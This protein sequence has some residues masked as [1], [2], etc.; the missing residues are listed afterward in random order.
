[1]TPSVPVC[2]MPS[3][4][5]ALGRIELEVPQG[6]TVAEIIAV[7]LPGATADALSRARVW[8][9]SNAGETLL[10][11][12]AAWHRIRPRPGVRV[13]IKL[14]AGD[15]DLKT[16]L[17]IAVSIAATAI[18]QVWVGPALAAATGSALIGQI[19]AAAVAAGIT[20]AGG[21]LINMLIP[22]A[23]RADQQS[24]PPLFSISGWQNQSA[25]D[26]VVPS[27][28]GKVRV[29]P[30]FAAP[31]YSE[32]V[33][34]D[35]YIRCLFTFGY[36]PV[37]LSGLKIKDTPLSSFNEVD[38]EIRDGYSSDDPVSIYPSQ[39][40][41]DSLGVE[42]RRDRTRNSSGDIT[43]TGPVT[44]VSRFTAGD[45]T[46]AN[47]IFSFPGGLTDFHEEGD[48]AGDP[49]TARVQ[50]RIRQ[51]PASGGSWQTVKT[52][53]FSGKTRV[54]FF[55]QYRWSLPS[56]GRWEIE[57]ARITHEAVETE[58]SD[59]STWLS[60]QSFRPEYPINF[61]KPL[62]LV[63]MRIKATYQLNSTLDTFNAIAERLIPDWDHETEQWVVRPTRNPASHFRHA[64]QGPERAFP[65]P[66]SAIDL[67]MLQDWHDFCRVKGLKYDRNRNF[68]ASIWDT[69]TEIAAAGRAAPRYD[70]TKWQVIIDR[71]QELV[72]AHINDRNSRDFKWSR[73]YP[74]FPDAFRVQFLDETNDYQERERIV[75]WPGY[76]GD[77]NVTEQLTMPGKTDP[78]EIWVE[79]RRRQYEAIY[80]PDVFT[81]VQD[82]AVR[83]ATRG[84]YVKGSY[85]TLSYTLATFRVSVVRDQYVT[86]DGWVEMEAGTNYAVR[87]MRQVGE[88][89]AATFESVLRQVVTVPGDS[90]S[91]ALAGDGYAPLAGDIVQFGI[92]GQESIDL[93]VAGTQAGE[94]MTSVLTMLA[95][96]P[97]IDQLTDAEVPP[98]WN[99][100]AGG[101]TAAPIDIPAVPVV[102]SIEPY[103]D[104]STGDPDGVIVLLHP[105]EG[106][107]A[108]VTSFTLRHRLEGTATW[109]DV[110]VD[111]ADGA[112][113]ATG[114]AS[115][116]E[117]EMQVLATSLYGYSSDWSDIFTASGA[118]ADP[119]P[120]PQPITS[121]SV[122]GGTGEAS[123]DITTANDIWIDTV[124]LYYGPNGD[125]SGVTLIVN[126]AADPLSNYERTETVP[127][128]TWYFF[129]VTFNSEGTPSVGFS[130]GQET[131]A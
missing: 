121:G 119:E 11:A 47:I 88:S 113:L 6:L 59:R 105:G 79:A 129:A 18:G 5:P 82:G 81:A 67:A 86:F 35:Q 60:L 32:I 53:T 33:G 98:E 116:A 25:P 15:I 54:G 120:T 102:S 122:T 71:P 94:N 117:I 76:T 26:G 104:P 61:D 36:G 125:G 12:R 101:D 93:V 91:V 123:F 89:D 100:R 40:I 34:D 108:Y 78:E 20:L 51:R 103:F 41:E 3:L 56:R 1:M 65:E 44:P 55:R 48:D 28:L 17:T 74:Q 24:E 69:L 21:Y 95:Q 130:L 87:F 43:G 77:I 2:A 75:R 19:G 70:G 118:A 38:Y 109:T 106:S 128:G 97:I 39:V 114:Y 52:I 112:A 63:A 7:V 92:A 90:D 8:L 30:V 107:S 45:A 37:D 58:I 14:V 66:D 115:G 124:G 9:V 84:D 85:E 46:E 27:V 62:C 31:T 42:L 23:G 64:L 83:T 126:F 29:A 4:D 99:G 110:T 72:V 68:D 57:C 131:I 127:S 111:A 73:N 50:I 96:A 16:V 80:R 22:P 13:M 10:S 49:K